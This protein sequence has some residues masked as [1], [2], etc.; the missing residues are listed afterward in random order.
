ML[1]LMSPNSEVEYAY[2]GKVEIQPL[3]LA[4]LDMTLA[5]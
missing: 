3:D 1:I 2:Y 4:G 5:S